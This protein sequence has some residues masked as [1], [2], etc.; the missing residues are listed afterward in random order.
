MWRERSGPATVAV[1]HRPR[2]D[3]WSLPKGKLRPGESWHAAALREIAEETGC[4]ARIV[5]F[6]GAKVQVDRDVPKLVVYWHM[7]AR[8]DG[9]L[10]A[11]GEVDEVAWLSP[12]EALARLDGASDRHVL[13][14][15]IA[16]YARRRPGS[17][18]ATLRGQIRERIVVDGRAGE[19]ELEAV[20]RLVERALAT[21]GGG[22]A[23]L[24]NAARR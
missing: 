6:A 3:D 9:A 7:E 15:A 10:D 20:V 24:A 13:L 8:R 19:R 11:S 16:G 18:P 17:R 4:E 22:A 23:R 12:A 2:R 5:G 21:G 1:I 14:R